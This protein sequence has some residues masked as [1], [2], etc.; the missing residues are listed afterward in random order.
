MT[1]PTPETLLLERA[2]QGDRQAV[3][4]LLT[5]YKNLVRQKASLMAVAGADR[6]DVIQEGMI[7]LYR[8]IQTY[9]PEKKVPFQAFASVCILSQIIDAVRRASRNKHEILNRS[10]SLDRPLADADPASLT[11]LDVVADRHGVN[12][13][14]VL[15]DQEG[16]LDLASFIQVDLSQ[17]ERQSLLLFLQDLTYQQIADTLGVSPKTVD[18]A[19]SRARQKI[20]RFRSQRLQANGG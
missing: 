15:L 8:A 2:G 10:L 18:N 7:G 11:G 14:Q 19:L 17:M 4:Q 5:R 9:Q 20:R 1:D 3:D 6:D 13:E 12:P 16:I